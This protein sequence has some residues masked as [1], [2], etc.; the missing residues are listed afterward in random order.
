MSK[1]PSIQEAIVSYVIIMYR[2]MTDLG[3]LK[4]MTGYGY[5]TGHTSSLARNMDVFL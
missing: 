1:S 3:Y 4:L 5:G 2:C